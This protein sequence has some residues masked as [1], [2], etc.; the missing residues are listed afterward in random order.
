[1]RTRHP[2]AQEWN[3]L[4]FPPSIDYSKFPLAIQA[5]MQEVT[6][7][8]NKGKIIYSNTH[9]RNIFTSILMPKNRRS[10]AHWRLYERVRAS[11]TFV[12][13]EGILKIENTVTCKYLYGKLNIENKLTTVGFVLNTA[14]EPY[15]GDSKITDMK[16]VVHQI[17]SS[18]HTSAAIAWHT[19]FFIRTFHE[20]ELH[21]FVL[22]NTE[23]R[24]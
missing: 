11:A 7:N 2:R 23:T 4:E 18:R 6:N 21:I 22:L 5:Y 1:M 19:Q 17:R 15:I 13:T 14:F 9:N 10:C 20:C 12:C 8:M 24:S 16:S 3:A